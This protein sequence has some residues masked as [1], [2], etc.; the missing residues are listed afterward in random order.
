MTAP[1]NDRHQ[2]ATPDGGR[3]GGRQLRHCLATHNDSER[4]GEPVCPGGSRTYPPPERRLSS[5][6][7][8]TGAAGAMF[9]GVWQTSSIGP[10]SN[11][12]CGV[13]SP[14]SANR[15][16]LPHVATAAVLKSKRS[17]AR[18]STPGAALASLVLPAQSQRPSPQR[19]GEPASGHGRHIRAPDGKARRRQLASPSEPMDL[20]LG[21]ACLRT[22][23]NVS[24]R[25]YVARSSEP[26]CCSR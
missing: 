3:P 11:L 16:I 21:P 2:A 25:Y 9:Q 26:R 20:S 8:G 12:N 13:R 6:G 17:S 5:A 7:A 18:Q 22:E 1:Y 10:E 14:G 15:L 19:R 24:G 4:D 23:T